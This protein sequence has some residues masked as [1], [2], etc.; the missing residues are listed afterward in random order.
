MADGKLSAEAFRYGYTLIDGV[1]SKTV[2][3]KKHMLRTPRGWAIQ[4]SVL[5]EAVALGATMVVVNAADTGITYKAPV[6][7]V[8]RQGFVIDRAGFGIQV[9]LPIRYWET[10]S[11]AVFQKTMFDMT[12]LFGAQ[13]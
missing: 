9:V 1:L 12:K 11:S 13:P 2:D 5:R 6:D 8:L 10:G 7:L 4:Q 3:S